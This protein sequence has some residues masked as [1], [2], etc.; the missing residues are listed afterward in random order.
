MKHWSPSVVRVAR[1]EFRLHLRDESDA[2]DVQQVSAEPRIMS[3][4]TVA[5]ESG[6]GYAYAL[7]L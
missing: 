4:C 5:L 2:H 1:A 6:R 3:L 7:R